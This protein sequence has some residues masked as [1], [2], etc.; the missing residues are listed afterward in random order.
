MCGC[1]MVFIDVSGGE[2]LI[3]S[4]ALKH[5]I[6]HDYGFRDDFFRYNIAF[7]QKGH[8]QQPTLC[9]ETFLTYALLSDAAESFLQL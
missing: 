3:A 9:V 6:G 1:E 4:G 5:S 8:L 7:R 2:S